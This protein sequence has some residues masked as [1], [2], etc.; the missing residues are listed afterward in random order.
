MMR[1]IRSW[2]TPETRASESQ[3][4]TSLLLDRSLAIARGDY[5]NI[6][7]QAAY[8]GALSLIDHAAGVASLSGQHSDALQ[9]H[10]STI[11]RS[12]VDTGESTWLIELGSDG[13]LRLV[14]VTVVDV[15]GSHDPR[16][17]LYTLQAQGPSEAV[18]LQRPGE[19]VLSFRLRVHGSTPWRGRPA[20]DS[21][22]TGALLCQLEAQMQLEAK[23]SPARVIA[24][25][26]VPSQSSDV[27]KLI[28]AGGIVGVSQAIASR[29]DPN[30]VR[31]GVIRNEV[32]APSVS[33]HEKLS[34]AICG[35]MGVPSDLVLGG[36]SES[37]SRESMRRFGSTT[38]QNLLVTIAREW[39]SKMG[40]ELQW[41]LDQLRSSDEVS[42]ARATGSRANAV[43]R[44]VDSGV[45]LPQALAIAGIN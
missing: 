6:R 40:T 23:V 42:R 38:V 45:P 1:S 39:E 22:G 31:A 36:T 43:S 14:P 10:L 26:A 32:T 20:L 11:A 9:G 8:R 13:G 34:I 3:D 7:S 21:T 15:R 41:N 28:G 16:S 35:A 33:L 19:S 44:L 25:G 17:W 30:P 24:V 27:S 2:F 12:M 4:Y 29:E 18:T 37:G 5:G